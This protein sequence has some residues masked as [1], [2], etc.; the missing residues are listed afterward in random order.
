M[1]ELD[2]ELMFSVMFGC[3]LLLDFVWV[4][5]TVGCGLILIYCGI[6][7]SPVRVRLCCLFELV[8][9][10]AG[11]FVTHDSF[12]LEVVFHVWRLFLT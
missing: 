5:C 2:F 12:V 6:L 10:R 1:Q 3:F 7:L 9:V 8:L 11:K 4:V